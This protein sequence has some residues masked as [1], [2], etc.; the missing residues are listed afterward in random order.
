MTPSVFQIY[1]KRVP[2]VDASK[3]FVENVN[4]T[5]SADMRIECNSYDEMKHANNKFLKIFEL[6]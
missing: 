6:R 5:I 1:S 3:Q 4:R 2:A